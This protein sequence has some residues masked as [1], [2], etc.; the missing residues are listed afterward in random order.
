MVGDGVSID[1]VSSQLL[2]PCDAEVMT[3]HP[4]GHAITLRT[5]TNVELILHIGLDTVALRGEGFLPLKKKGDRVR[6][7]EPL[8]DFAPDYVA[9]RAPSLLTQMVITNGEAV[10]ALKPRTGFVVAGRDVVLEATLANAAASA[11]TVQIGEETLASREL[12]VLD[13]TGLHARP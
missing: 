1:P 10:T 3:V 9:T 2:A 7:G 8:I 5:P 13:P 12:E 6:A 11:V 4:S